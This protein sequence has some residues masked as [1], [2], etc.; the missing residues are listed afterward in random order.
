MS[1]SDSTRHSSEVPEL[2]KTGIY[3]PADSAAELV[4]V[5]DQYLADLQAGK[6]PDREKLL[7]DHPEL[8]LELE[9][10]LAGIEFVH[11]AAKPSATQTPAQLGDFRIVREVGRGGMGV[12]YEAEQ[13]SLKRKVALKVLR[14]GVTAD[15]DVMQRFQREAETVA[16]LH[17]TN[18][19][20]IHAVGCEQG[21]HY[22]AM[23]FI[24]G[25]SLAEVLEDVDRE[26]SVREGTVDFKEIAGWTLQ[27]AEALAHA[28]HRGV[29]HRDI[30]PSNLILDPEGTVWLTDFGLAKRADEV[31]MTA[32]GVVMGT[33]RYMS[34]E[35]AA[36]AKQPVDHRTDIYSLGATLYELATGKPVFDSQT[37]QG[38]ITQI[39]NAEPIRPRILQ[40]KLPRDLETIILKCLAKEPAKRYQ[41]AR[42]L[43]DDLRAY[44]DNR[45]IRA[46]RAS[47]VE[48][49]V[50][51]ARKHQRST[52]IS[53]V[54]VVASL[55]VIFGSLTAW[56][57]YRESLNGRLLLTTDGPSLIAEVL[58][59][60][61]ELI[62]ASFPVP[63]PQPVVLPSGNYRVRLSG[64]G[65][66]SET[67]QIDVE[68][69]RV[70]S[71]PV[72]LANRLLTAP[73]EV[74]TNDTPVPIKL[75]GQ[76]H[77]FHRGERG[78][79]LTRGDTLKPVW[80]NDL[81]KYPEKPEDAP[82]PNTAVWGAWHD[83]LQVENISYGSET[84]RSPGLTQPATDVNSDQR[85]DLILASR[86]SPSLVAVSGTDGKVLWWYR[87]LPNVP[88]EH[89]ATQDP[90]DWKAS[91]EEAGVLGE[92]ILV[93]INGE[94]A[95]IAT[96]VS[97]R[98]QLHTKSGKEFIKLRSFYVD[99][100][101]A[102]TG[103]PLWRASFDLPE[104]AS[105]YWGDIVRLFPQPTIVDSD[106][107]PTLLL[108]AGTKLFG[109]DLQTGKDAWPLRELGGRPCQAVQFA[110]VDGDRKPE[111]IVVLP[112]ENLADQVITKVLSPQTG[113]VLWE[114]DYFVTDHL[115]PNNDPLRK[116]EL[117]LATDLDQ[118]GKSE[119][120]MGT[121][122]DWQKHDRH[123][124]GLE[125][126]EGATGTTR[127]QRRL[128]TSTT[129]YSTSGGANGSIRF[130]IG[131]DLN[132]DRHPEIFVT[133]VSS[134][135]FVNQQGWA[136]RGAGRPPPSQLLRLDAC[137][138]KGGEIVWRK[139][140][141]ATLSSS[142]RTSEMAWW[143]AAEDGWPQ[144]MVPVEKGQHEQGTT[145]FLSA[146]NGRITT[147]LPEIANPQL[148]DM[149]G[150]DLLD[151]YCL[152][153][154]QGARRLTV[155]KGMPPS[156]W[157]RPGNWQPARDFDGDGIVDFLGLEGGNLGAMAGTDHHQ[158][159]RADALSVSVSPG[160]SVIHMDVNG[161]QT[162]DIVMLAGYA[163]EHRSRTG[164]MAISGRDGKQIWLSNLAGLNGGSQ[165]SSGGWI[166]GTYRYP[167]LDKTDLNGDGRDE[168]LV[169]TQFDIPG[170]NDL[171]LACVSSVD[172]SA[173]WKVPILPGSFQ[174]ASV[175]D[176]NL[177]H[178]LNA[179]GF[180]DLA[181]WV[182]SKGIPSELQAFSGRDGSPL[183]PTST[184]GTPRRA[185]A[186]WPRTA[187]AD[188]DGDDQPE[189]IATATDSKGWGPEGYVREL[190]ILNGRDGTLKWRWPWVAGNFNF[191]PPLIVNMDGNRTRM[192]CMAIGGKGEGVSK[193]Q[194][195]NIVIFDP[196]GK[197]RETIP[198]GWI[199]GSP[200]WAAVDCD[201][202]GKD[203][204][205]YEKDSKFLA[206]RG[207]DRT[208]LWQRPAGPN[209]VT[210]EEFRPGKSNEPGE[211]VLWQDRTLLVWNSANGTTK[212]RCE[213]PRQ[214][215]YQLIANVSF[216]SPG[217]PP[218]VA[219][220]GANTASTIVQ[221]AL[222]TN[223]D[224]IYQAPSGRPVTLVEYQE[225]VRSRPLPWRYTFRLRTLEWIVI[226]LF[227]LP[228]LIV[229]WRQQKW[230]WILIYLGVLCLVSVFLGVMFFQ[231]VDNP[232]EPG[233][234]YS[235]E[236]WYLIL[237]QSAG[238]L[239]LLNALL[240]VIWLV[241][242]LGRRVLFGPRAPSGA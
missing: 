63:N 158:L 217:E 31:T 98:S 92:P 221:R 103:K 10:C 27:A 203:E 102:R 118:D 157:R 194:A 242:T 199:G 190:L 214:D 32:A 47:I 62:T 173:Q 155:L 239:G 152:A 205:L 6:T 67:W 191:W 3:N 150:D 120:I 65:A 87:A 30:K 2:E 66:L 9:D 28:H 129:A 141:P 93:N 5:L 108:Q 154:T 206:Y 210:L 228:P 146:S 22:Y 79:R 11:R 143:Q 142:N 160:F 80:P 123:W 162:S 198:V 240:G 49:T 139:E 104:W 84:G 121:R 132:G 41:N 53:A 105:V 78:W 76:M 178:D 44:M 42:D 68:R 34:P 15:A 135:L 127:W 45:P 168:I 126:I 29:I 100:I 136:D 99:A 202:D 25:R 225:P 51:W 237:F 46:R 156:D 16:H 57:V 56:N 234:H 55:L 133:S 17:H 64:S 229:W 211:L 109:F 115:E 148:L 50:R 36:A 77:L 209:G 179:D 207:S 172:G 186:V 73:L 197:I 151:L 216:Q 33:P 19:V 18:V 91:S 70:T 14:F 149:D 89:D 95:V 125:V 21:V 43:A 192:I 72:K 58:N 23:Q 112:K 215:I 208:Y 184:E 223:P 159:W 74:R 195:N 232:L 54:S 189:V 182:S 131:P 164:L 188:L 181:L 75:N 59:E 175:I 238:I 227:F 111:A 4:R 235:W 174:G 161:D 81:Q 128:A 7:A 1:N 90:V 134:D 204:V 24:E 145:Y 107:R 241:V 94:P 230:H 180:L 224:G 71:Y 140:V 101:A 165:S 52:T 116:T 37:P 170:G 222:P 213:V 97:L 169:A 176:R 147:M 144:L 40:G 153:D 13:I 119:I 226:I 113:H 69:G 167:F 20:P 106:G 48:R 88:P 35:Q 61:D 183:W 86:V 26:P 220:V 187:I 83:L 130:L 117:A 236:G 82:Y 185:W 124:Y 231:F 177:Y 138:G 201:G 233:E 171:H 122:D 39:L 196:K 137:S 114:R 110:D 218:L 60:K 200:A 166:G 193:E 212:W 12:V 96:M 163:D 38:V 85:D 8:A 219:S